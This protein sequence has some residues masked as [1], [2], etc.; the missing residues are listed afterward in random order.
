MKLI[1]KLKYNL[2]SEIW[3]E[4]QLQRDAL[5][6][7][8]KKKVNNMIDNMFDDMTVRIESS[9]ENIVTQALDKLQKNYEP[10]D[11]V[12]LQNKKPVNEVPTKNNVTVDAIVADEEHE[13]NVLSDNGNATLTEKSITADKNAE[14]DIPMNGH[15]SKSFELIDLADDE[16]NIENEEIDESE[17]SDDELS[18]DNGLLENYNEDDEFESDAMYENSKL[19]FITNGQQHQ[20]QDDFRN[21]EF[22]G[23]QFNRRR[24]IPKMDIDTDAEMASELSNIKFGICCTISGCNEICDYKPSLDRHLLDI[25]GINPYICVLQGCS[26]SFSER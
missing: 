5:K 2:S 24:K 12:P 26:R 10:I 22:V 16:E 1:D 18:I 11:K 6:K 20:Q 8:L 17:N 15:S 25:H 9:L 3:N 23:T 14:T 21:A 19:N 13:I 7:C 4:F